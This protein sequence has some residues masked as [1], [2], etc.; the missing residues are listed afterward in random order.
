MDGCFFDAFCELATKTLPDLQVEGMVIHG[1][2]RH[3]SSGAKISELTDLIKAGPSER[4]RDLLAKAA[5]G[6]HAVSELP[7]PVVAAISGCCLGSALELALACHVRI[8]AR[9]AV[10]ALPETTLGLMPGCGAT[11]RLPELVGLGKAIE[12]ILAG[13]SLLATEAK[14]TGLV[15]LVVDK[16][17]LLGSAERLI[18]RLNRRAPAANA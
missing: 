7:F 11:A 4:S 2:G 15:D 6:F 10:L 8:A 18:H 5:L 14:R 13:R 12:L 9:N 16:R 1:S 17:H 3:F